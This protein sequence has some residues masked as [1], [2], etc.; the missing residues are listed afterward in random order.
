MSRPL[1]IEYEGAFYPITARGNELLFSQRR[2]FVWLL[3]PIFE[4]KEKKPAKKKA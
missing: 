2:M 3:I 4:R 1:R